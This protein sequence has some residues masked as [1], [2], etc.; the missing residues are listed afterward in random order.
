MAQVELENDDANPCVGC[1][2]GN[3]R[4]LR[5]R[6]RKDGD[7]VVSTLEAHPDFQGWPGLLH[8]GIIYIAM[9]ETANW[10]LYGQIGRVGMPVKTSAL[11]T[12]SRVKVGE[13]IEMSGRMVANTPAAAKVDVEAAGPDGRRVA[14]LSREYSLASEEEF[15]R[16]MGYE[17]T[18]K[19][20]EGLFGTDAPRTT[21][22]T[23]SKN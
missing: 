5:L 7:R 10:T 11:E 21:R 12:M 16:R 20:L 6:F 4:G 14:T 3:P 17:K 18:P 1:G 8:T 23:N 2:P 19:V 22:A 15:A 9:L 13:T